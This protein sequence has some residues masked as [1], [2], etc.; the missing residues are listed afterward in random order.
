MSIKNQVLTILKN[1]D[2]IYKGKY[3]INQSLMELINIYI[4]QFVRYKNKQNKLEIDTL[5]KTNQECNNLYNDLYEN[6]NETLQTI[7]IKQKEAHDKSVKALNNADERCE[8]FIQKIKKDSDNLLDQKQ[9]EYLNQIDYI[10]TQ[11]DDCNN[12]IKQDKAEYNKAYLGMG[13]ELDETRLKNKELID[14]YDKLNDKFKSMESIEHAEYNTL[15]QD[16]NRYHR[17]KNKQN[18][19]EIDTLLKTNQECNNLYNDLY[20]NYNETLQTI[21]IK[22]KEA[23]DKSVK[24]LNNADERCEKFIQ[25]IKKDSDNLLD[26][27][28]S[29]YLNQIDYIRTQLDDCNNMIKQDKAEYNKAYL[30]MGKELDETRLKNKELIDKY[31]KLNDKFKSMESIEHAEYNTLIQ[32]NNRYHKIVLEYRDTIKKYTDNIQKCKD[33]INDKNKAIISLQDKLSTKNKHLTNI[34]DKNKQ[35]HT[36]QTNINN[37]LKDTIVKEGVCM[38]KI[39]EHYRLLQQLIEDETHIIDDESSYKSYI[40]RISKI[41]LSNK[42]LM[43]NSIDL[44]KNIDSLTHELSAC[45]SKK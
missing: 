22:Q 6:Y 11:L 16:N 27:K 40:E 31:D 13:K 4:K 3:N 26:Q 23:H 24:A 42:K 41:I 30:G 1:H 17:Y 10:R 8:K 34:I 32:D 15:I 36:H 19:L 7:D 5:L 44:H 39:K 2:D 14:K 33:T 25:K 37:Q 45:Q 38:S 28:Q 29:E 18:K 20:E 43:E 12:M 35:D 9:S 21:D